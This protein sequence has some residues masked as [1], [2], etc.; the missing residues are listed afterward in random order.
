[1]TV[2]KGAGFLMEGNLILGSKIVIK[3]TIKIK[4]TEQAA[5]LKL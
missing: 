3:S 5:S 1:M 2:V 4:K